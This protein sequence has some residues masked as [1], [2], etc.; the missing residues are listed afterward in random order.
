MSPER[1]LDNLQGACKFFKENLDKELDWYD[2][3]EFVD[4]WYVMILVNDILT[5]VGSVLKILIENKVSEQ[6][7][8]R[9]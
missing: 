4:L 9:G 3:L 6:K 7:A 8:S 1:T 5:L 2:R